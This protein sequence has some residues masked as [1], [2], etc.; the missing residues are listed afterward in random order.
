MTTIDNRIL[1][2]LD[3]I[4]ILIGIL[5]WENVINFHR[6]KHVYFR[7]YFACCVTRDHLLE[8]LVFDTEHALNLLHAS[9]D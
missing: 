1:N 2:F 3:C 6:R 8:V 5:H 7:Q 9:G 4:L